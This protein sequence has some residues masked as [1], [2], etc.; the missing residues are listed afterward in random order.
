MRRESVACSLA[1]LALALGLSCTRQPEPADPAYA[2]AIEKARAERVAAL[3]GEGSWLTLVGIHWLKPGTNRLGS[4]A[5]NEIVIKGEGVPALVGRIEVAAGGGATFVGASG[6]GATVR[7]EPI[8][9]A[10]ALRSDR[11]GKTDLVEVAGLRMS[12][13]DRSGAL[14][15]RVRDPK[16]PRRTGF[17]GIPYFP[18]DTDLRVDAILDRYSTPKE[19]M[20]ASAQGPAQKML[21]PGLLRFRIGSTECTLEPFA[22]SA[23]AEL[24]VVFADATSGGDSYGAGRFLDA[25]A[26]APGSGAVVL[27]FNLAYNPPCAFTPYATCPLPPPQNVLPVAISAGEKT[28][29]EH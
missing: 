13:I 3:T 14:A 17:K 16:S 25:P 5:G 4:A 21:A 2:A 11:Q 10:V 18:V 24:F 22:D 7:G 27:D 6:G 26:P 28:P 23:D 1:A 8:T 19:V 9:T 29:E 12:L 20:V 15:L